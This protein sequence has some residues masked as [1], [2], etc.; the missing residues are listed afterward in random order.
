MRITPKP[1][2]KGNPMTELERDLAVAEYMI[3]EV[4]KI[5]AKVANDR[6]GCS[7]FETSS[8]ARKV[9]ALMAE[10]LSVGICIEGAGGIRP[11]SGGK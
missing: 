5:A 10:A 4:K 1:E 7:D 6:C 9:E 2:P 11:L 3:C 8:R